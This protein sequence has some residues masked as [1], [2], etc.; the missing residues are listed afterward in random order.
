MTRLNLLCFESLK[1]KE[2]SGKVP[3]QAILS[4]FISPFCARFAALLVGLC[5]VT[6]FNLVAEN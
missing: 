6:W 3:Q 5:V 4:K 2:E 1:E